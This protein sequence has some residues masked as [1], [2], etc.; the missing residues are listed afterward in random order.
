MFK[1]K[2]LIAVI[3]FSL[4]SFAQENNKL[5]STAKN[6]FELSANSEY[7]SAAK[8]FIYSDENTTAYERVINPENKNELRTVKKICKKIKGLLKISSS[9]NFGDVK[10]QNN[11]TIVTV[12][13]LSTGQ[14][15]SF[16]I[17]FVKFN[18]EYKLLSF[19]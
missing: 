12:N 16:I 15:L 11:T 2:I 19:K 18:D 17:K 10:N 3:F 14:D 8:Y 9:Y 13:F 7:K 4:I 1:I 5:I 6:I